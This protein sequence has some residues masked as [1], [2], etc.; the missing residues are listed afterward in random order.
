MNFEIEIVVEK[1][2]RIHVKQ[3]VIEHLH[4]MVYN[5]L[6]FASKRKQNIVIYVIKFY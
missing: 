3:L 2:I 4:N 6:C 1:I 5:K